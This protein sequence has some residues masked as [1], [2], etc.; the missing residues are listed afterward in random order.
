MDGP[1]WLGPY[2]MKNARLQWPAYAKRLFNMRAAGTHPPRIDV[3]FGLPWPKEPLP[4]SCSDWPW[5]PQTP[6]IPSIGIPT[7]DY[8]PGR[9]DLRV[10]SGIAT[11]IHWGR[12]HRLFAP[13]A[14]LQLAAECA[15]W[16]DA[17]WVDPPG[18][19]VN[20]LAAEGR[21]PSPEGRMTFPA[22]WPASLDRDYSMRNIAWQRRYD[23]AVWQWVDTVR[24]GGKRIRPGDGGRLADQAA[25][26]EQR[27]P[28]PESGEPAFDSRKRPGM[29][30][31]DRPG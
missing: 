24:P 7:D 2:A 28:D 8:Q 15:R 25:E 5:F 14:E 31:R 11:R 1:R 27:P 17:V 22:W 30:R 26:I 20:I 6:A 18:T 16:A 13:G 4:S 12:D 9:Y 10:L 23:D 29:E 19:A 21:W 3:Y